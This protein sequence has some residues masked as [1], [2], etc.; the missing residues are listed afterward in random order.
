MENTSKQPQ[1]K[2]FLQLKENFRIGI[3]GSSS[4][5]K[6]Q[7][8][9]KLLTTP[10]LFRKPI[11]RVYYV[12]QH[13][14]PKYQKQLISHFGV[15]NC[16][17]VKNEIPEVFDKQNYFDKTKSQVIIIDDSLQLLNKQMGERLLNLLTTVSHHSNISVIFCVQ[18]LTHGSNQYLRIMLRNC[19]ALILFSLSFGFDQISLLANRCFPQYKKQFL[20]FYKDMTKHKYRSIMVSLLPEENDDLRIKFNILQENPPYLQ[21]VWCPTYPA[22]HVFTPGGENSDEEQE[23]T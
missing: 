21:G 2:P 13:L 19:T 23:T 10:K 22:K 4:T 3:I 5:G 9:I 17:F 7:F 11:E 1:T 15:E 6:T 12:Y 16:V 20:Q 8:T 18:T 14:Q